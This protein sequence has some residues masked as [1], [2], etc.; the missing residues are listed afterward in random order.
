MKIHPSINHTDGIVTVSL[1]AQ[2]VGDATDDADRIKIQAYGDPKVDLGGTF[3]D[4]ND[5]SFVFSTGSSS[6]LVGITQDMHNNP[7][8][9]LTALPAAVP[10]KPAPVQGP[11]QV[12][13]P[14]PVRAVQI[15]RNAIIT[16]IIA[17]LTTFRA[18]GAP[19]TTLSDATV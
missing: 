4:P 1:Q 6:V 15:W 11:L 2:F 17:S 16:R 14:D 5:P 19:L 8:Q 13:T 10:G 3:V 18:Q 12:I 7:V 9:L